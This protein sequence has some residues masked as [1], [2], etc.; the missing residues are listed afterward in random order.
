M[1]PHPGA[2]HV[3]G[4]DRFRCRMMQRA[5]RVH[6]IRALGLA[7]LIALLSWGGLETYGQL[8]AAG[9]VESLETAATEDVPR[10]IDRIAGY[11]RWARPRLVQMLAKHDLSSRADL[12]ARLA[13]LP[14]D[15]T[16]ADPL[17]D[18]LISAPPAD[19]RI[20][21]RSL[22]P[23][24][25]RV[26]PKLWSELEKTRQG[27]SGLLASAIAL[28]VYDPVNP[29]W[30]ELGGKVA[31][32]LVN[33]NPV[34]LGFW[35]DGLRP[36]RGRLVAPLEAI[37]GDKARPEIEH[38]LV[39]NILADYCADAPDRLAGLLMTADPKA[40]RTLFPVA[41]RQAE[42]IVPEFQA[43]LNQGMRFDWNDPKVDSS[44][45]N[46]D[47]AVKNRIEAALG[48]VAERF[49]FCQTMPLDEYLA[50][51]DALRPSGY[52]PVRFRPYAD[53]PT[54]R[55]AGVWTRD[56]RKWR[57]ASGLAADDVLKQVEQNRR[58]NLIPVDV[59]GYVVIDSQG[60]P[61]DRY[62]AVWVER[63]NPQDDAQ[64]YVGATV[65]S[66]SSEVY[67]LFEAKL[68]PWTL[69]TM[70]AADGRTRYSGVC[71]R[72]SSQQSG[73]LFWDGSV[74]ALQGT[75]DGGSN[76]LDVT[77]S[78][79]EPPRP[80]R[81]LAHASLEI[82]NGSLKIKPDDV[83]TR[84]ARAMALIGLGEN[85]K[86]LDDL[87]IVVQQ[88]PDYEPAREYR[89]IVHARLGHKQDALNDQKRFEK[90]AAPENGKL[91]L[92]AMLAIE[93][94]EGQEQALAR[95]DAALKRQLHD[96]RLLYNAACVYALASKALA[97][98]DRAGARKRMQREPSNCSGQ[99]SRTASRTM[100]TLI[101]TQTSIRSG[102]CRTLAI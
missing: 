4:L 83:N 10:I 17:Y 27:D 72:S 94:G 57:T 59:A 34:F 9:L 13:L 40:Y 68:S 62:S 58:D 67:R 98:S 84:W 82:A 42:N 22:E 96:S 52:R 60:K 39:T 97:R 3:E 36:V 73:Q 6:G 53:G 75:L 100:L 21:I 49:A 51:T 87:N 16:Q 15:A 44:W 14:S 2:H 30:A 89:A 81:E 102:I 1:V 29:R 54:V 86:A 33:L 11:R 74:G 5:G 12:H 93:W 92:A 91:C 80:A 25:A 18:R 31:E 79:A 46:P 70:R 8:H 101:Q 66:R 61:G 76:L 55:V 45:K 85:Q 64:V 24:K 48:L 65:A 90:A 95:L 41:E 32:S 37:F 26:E 78:A 47:P 19:L 20:L 23:Y 69:Q 77:V 43:E 35:L 7:V 28:A 38:D 50:T 88:A 63:A 71:G 99:R 56:T